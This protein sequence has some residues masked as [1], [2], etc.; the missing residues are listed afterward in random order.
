MNI[1]FKSN[2]FNRITASLTRKYILIFFIILIIP[3]IVIYNLII[4]YA[5]R[6]M[7]NDIVKKNVLMT[8]SLVKRLDTEI[9]DVVLQLELIAGQS[10]DG[11]LDITT[12]YER[13]KQAISKSSIIHSVYYIDITNR[14]RFEAPFLPDIAS[15]TYHYPVFRDV[16]WTLNY[17]VSGLIHN[18]RGQPVVT[19]AIPVFTQKEQ[20]GGVLV[21]ELSQE[22]LSE[23]LLGNSL[24]N[25][26]F[27]FIVDS[28][29]RIIA[30][31]DKSKIGQNYANLPVIQRLLSDTTGAA[32]EMI[33]G[34]KSIVTYQM[35]RD[36]W[37][38]MTGVPEKIAFQPVSELS[39][40]LRISFIGILILSL[41]LVALGMRHILYP[42]IRL[43]QLAKFFHQE[44]SLREIQKL[45]RFNSRDELGVLM[46][47][48]SLVGFS[49]FE[50]QKKLEENER[51]LHDVIEGMPYAIISIDNDG[52]VSY[53][54]HKYEELT[55][56]PREKI[57]G[58]HVTQL[59][60]KDNEIE[61]I[62]LQAFHSELDFEEKESY[63]FDAGRHKRMVKVIT[64]K[65]YN[66]AQRLMGIIAVFQD[67]SH[68]KLLEAHAKQSEKLA[69]IGQI[70][71][72]IAHEIKNPLAILSG[73][74]ELLK[75]EIAATSAEPIVVELAED[76]YRVVRRMNGIVNDFLSFARVKEEVFEPVQ[77]DQLLEEVLRLLRV[78]LGEMKVQVI[79]EYEDKHIRIHGKADKLM[80][81]FLN[82]VLNSID[83][84]PSGGTL[85]IGHYR[86]REEERNWLVI[87]VEDSGIG[88]H[89]ESLDWLFNP[90]FSMKEGG[91][92]LGLT[93]ARDI[94]LEHGGK[95]EIKSQPQ[96]GTTILCKFPI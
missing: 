82:L 61:S 73:A 78:K 33:D 91:S 24:T 5:N 14:V 45:S 18:Y 17:V 12:M 57:K 42:I 43:T 11:N 74:S 90:F 89:A 88:I 59:P 86:I 68:L 95:I 76:I 32:K 21:A 54:N 79:R 20:F 44:A 56:Y 50:K 27:S 7:E 15:A 84:M 22:Y 67:I 92:G 9:T 31:N 41:F 53:L 16:E 38:L 28:S 71:T 51:Y 63:I 96:M 60:M 3:I 13:A 35:L 72:G 25:N 77:M 55:G 23:V 70:T 29:G 1:G 48:I 30:S 10:A 40:S 94:M 6:V 64:S 46:R 36:Y 80:Q 81:V 62:L 87:S 39:L 34:E 69:V 85:K 49:N 93:I 58:V 66:E 65:F 2:I 37:G 19:V 4:G 47:T 8:D 26:G 52:K 83:A 75:E